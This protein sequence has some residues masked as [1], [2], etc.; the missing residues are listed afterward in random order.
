MTVNFGFKVG[1][2]RVYCILC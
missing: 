2:G 1:G